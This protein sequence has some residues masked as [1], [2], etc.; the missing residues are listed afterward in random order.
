[1]LLKRSVKHTRCYGQTPGC[2]P[3]RSLHTIK[4]HR[5]ATFE[6]NLDKLFCIL[7]SCYAGFCCRFG[8][9]N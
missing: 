4:T 3:G 1:M 6:F 5:K 8:Y 2:Q 9:L 7:R